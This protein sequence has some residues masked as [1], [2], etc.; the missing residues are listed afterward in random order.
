MKCLVP[1]FCHTQVDKRR[2]QR[3]IEKHKKISN[4]MKHT[5]DE[6]KQKEK[7]QEWLMQTQT[8]RQMELDRKKTTFFLIC[9]QI[10]IKEIGTFVKSIPPSVWPTLKHLFLKR[11]SKT[12]GA[13]TSVRTYACRYAYVQKHKHPYVYIE[14]YIWFHI[15]TCV[16]IFTM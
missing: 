9:V 13:D 10:P 15:F 5:Q 11:C 12:G 4:K 14:I 16:Y 2:R 8:K 3:P 6:H 1:V 7:E